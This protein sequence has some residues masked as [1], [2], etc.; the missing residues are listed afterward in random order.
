MPKHYSDIE[1]EALNIV[2]EEKESWTESVA[3]VTEKVAFD[4]RNLIRL[5]RKN[6]WGVFNT[7]EDPITRRKK[8]WIPLTESLVETAVKNIDLDTKDINFRAKKRD[9]VGLTHLVRS[10]VKNNL[11]EIYFGETLDEMERNLA[12]D[13]TAVWK[14]LEKKDKDGRTIMDIRYVDLLNCYIDP[15]SRSIQ[16][17][18]RFTERALMNPEEV[19]AM[20]GWINTEGLQGNTFLSRNDADLLSA[21]ALQSGNYVDVWELW[22]RIPKYLITGNEKDREEEVE[23]HIVVSG[24]EK[25]GDSRVHLIEEN[26]KAIKPYEEA[27]YTRVSGRWYGRGIAEK[28]MM[29]QSWMNIV[30]NIRITRSFVSQ[31]GIFKIKRNRGVTPQMLSRLSANGAILVQ[32]MDDIEQMVVQDASPASYKDEDTIQN[33]AERVTSAFEVVTG[34][35]LPATTSATATALQSRSAQS[36]FV[37]I[38]EGVGMFIQRWLKRQALPI[39]MKHMKRDDVIRV[40]G[41][42][43]DLRI[44]D[45]RIV[46][47]RALKELRKK[48]EAGIIFDEAQ[49]VQEIQ[50][51]VSK[52]QQDGMDRY[53]KLLKGIDFSRFDVQVFVTNEEIDKGVLAQNLLSA[54]QF[55]PEF[56]DQIM[57][58]LFDLMGVRMRQPQLQAPQPQQGGQPQMTGEQLPPSQE[59]PASRPISPSQNPRALVTEANTLQ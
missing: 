15:T 22:G 59:Q 54:L 38:R 56:K 43:D 5:L 18:Y 30:V 2:R 29:L 11:D 45:E 50:R 4:V 1:R 8:T 7:P 53:V 19:K 28:V 44:L 48:H 16:E 6:Y 31:L 37:L 13:G 24:L 46:M 27:W 26:K 35:S 40:T 14:T 32:D 23:G 10:V 39:I 51:A 25:Q 34:E 12:I 41:E 36:Q 58:H 52:F 33:W 47:G 20:K 3:F 17:A 57:E 9:A 21:N 55:A 42:L 49:A